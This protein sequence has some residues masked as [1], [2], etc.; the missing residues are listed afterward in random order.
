M[1]SPILSNFATNAYRTLGLCAAASQA[2]IDQAARKMRI[3]PDPKSIPPTPWD[4]PWLGPLSR[5]RND[6]EHALSRLNDPHARIEERLMWFI[7]SDPGSW[8]SQNARG[9]NKKL[10]RQPPTHDPGR[11]HDVALARLQVAL[12]L[13]PSFRSEDRWIKVLDTLGELSDSHDLVEF[14]NHIEGAGNFEKQ[15]H[16][17][18]IEKAAASLQRR[19]VEPL[20]AWAESALEDDD[21][22]RAIRVFAILRRGA[23]HLFESYLARMARRLEDVIVRRC[24]HLHD[25]LNGVGGS[26]M[27]DAQKL[28]TC[29]AQTRFY[30]ES[31]EPL[32]R[33]LRDMAGTDPN[34]LLLVRCEV[35][36]AK[37]RL[38]QCWAMQR[39]FRKARR[40]FKS[41]LQM[42]RGTPVE[43]PI[44]ENLARCRRA[45]RGKPPGPPGTEAPVVRPGQPFIP[46]FIAYKLPKRTTAARF[47]TAAILIAGLLSGILNSN[48]PVT[49]STGQ[50]PFIPAQPEVYT[51]PLDDLAITS[52]DGMLHKAEFTGRDPSGSNH[53]LVD[54]TT[55]DGPMLGSNPETQPQSDRR[56]Y[57]IVGEEFEF[58]I[59]RG[60]WGLVSG[61]VGFS[62][63]PHRGI[64]SWIPQ[65]NQT[66]RID[67]EL[68]ESAA[69]AG[70]HLNIAFECYPFD[71]PQMVRAATAAGSTGNIVVSWQPPP[72]IGP[73]SVA[74][75]E[76]NLV[77]ID[78]SQS[79]TQ[80]LRGDATATNVH[81]L[82]PGEY[83]LSLAAFN[84]RGTRG[85]FYSGIFQF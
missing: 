51:G 36:R 69:P 26:R 68:A 70:A 81:N 49:N 18:E 75:F 9:V 19:I 25:D 13:D 83:M 44:E 59:N 32:L 66:G 62:F 45:I 47:I 12:I 60:I 77:N 63:D 2:Q 40:L 57:A 67:V 29:K 35:A 71:A 43:R 37:A 61:P 76:L 48:H 78:S 72:G 27:N 15:A 8:N 85:R 5:G 79:W 34:A 17:H 3:W 42:G 84:R 58:V 56:Q 22:T 16:P 46:T 41:A 39:R 10:D 14:L 65:P 23:P 31:I 50:P 55:G 74:G 82:P 28:A 52:N 21:L 64:G 20:A 38:G 4:L 80:T 6:I 24:N 30:R 33:Q 53:F 73:E 54:L 11:M 1:E 7:G